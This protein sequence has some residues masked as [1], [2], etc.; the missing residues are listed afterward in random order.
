MITIDLDPS[1]EDQIFID[2][3]QRFVTELV[4]SGPRSTPDV[5]FATP[6]PTFWEQ[7]CELGWTSTLGPR[8]S[9][10]DNKSFAIRTL[11]SLCEL[12]GR[13]LVPGPLVTVTAVQ[14]LLRAAH[15]VAISTDELFDGLGR[16]TSF[17]G[18]VGLVP[19]P[20]RSVITVHTTGDRCEVSGWDS[21]VE[22]AHRADWLVVLGTDESGRAHLVMA[23][24][25]HPRLA[26]EPIRT[27]D[28]GRSFSRVTFDSVPSS[29]LEV[30]DGPEEVIASWRRITEMCLILNA[31]DMLG[32]TARLLEDCLEYLSSRFTFGRRL[33]SYQALKHRVADH[34]TKLHGCAAVIDRAIDRF[35]FRATARQSEVHAA[36]YYVSHHVPEILQDCVQMF[37]GIGVTLEHHAHHCLRRVHLDRYLYGDPESHLD[38]IAAHGL[39]TSGRTAQ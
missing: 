31:A 4:S 7:A 28:G 24:A 19:D 1:I 32:V 20:R 9:P 38:V 27:I 15:P 23:D 25:H 6:W 37:G 12:R 22:E 39:L 17:A 18:L 11:A 2:V 14:E 8:T 34:F 35:S 29:R 36:A 5:A 10:P 33:N 13:H 3:A 21:C 16:G 26:T 30:G